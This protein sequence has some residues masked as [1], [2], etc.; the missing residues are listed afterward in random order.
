MSTDA[1]PDEP[2]RLLSAY[3][4]RFK[5][6]DVIFEAG[7]PSTEAYLLQDG[8]VRLIKRAGSRERSLRVIRPGDL[9]GEYALVSGTSRSSTAVALV[10]SAA[11]ALDLQTFE[12]VL[13][14]NPTLGLRVLQQLV[15]RLRDADDQI[16]LLMLRDSQVKIAAALL[17]LGHEAARARPDAT[18]SVV[19]SVSPLELSARVGLDV[20]TVKRNVQQLR[21]SGHLVIE[22][23]QIQI[24]DL[25]GLSELRRL[26]EMKEEIAGGS[27]ASRVRRQD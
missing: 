1:G 16:E 23:E 20:E 19:L 4:R 25:D 15:R 26:L 12:E 3:L 17:Q 6:G 24:H 5:A 2:P 13:T 10:D 14:A 22:S 9:F 18:D 21:A 27:E 11:L 8:R 7:S